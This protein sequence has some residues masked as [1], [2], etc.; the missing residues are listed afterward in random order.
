MKIFTLNKRKLKKKIR[1]LSIFIV[2]HLSLS[3]VRSVLLTATA[4]CIL[5]MLTPYIIIR[6]SPTEQHP[7]NDDGPPAGFQKF[8]IPKT[9]QVYRTETGK[10][11]TIDFE[12]YI[13]GVVSCEM[14]S[15]FH[16]EA[17]KAQAVAARTYSAAKAAAY[18]TD[19]N[20]E[21]HPDAP[22][23]DST[24]CQVYK[25]KN[26]LKSEKGS[27]WINSGWKKI[28]N[29]VDQTHGQ[30]L[31]YNGELVKQ[32]LFHSSSGGKTENSEDVFASAVPYLVSVDSPYEE[33]AT[34]QNEKNSFSI[35]E[36]KNLIE[37]NYPSISIGAVTAENTRIL[38]RSSGGSVKEIQIGDAVL[39]G[40]QIREALELP[41]AGF[42]IEISEDKITFTSSGSGHGVGMSQ[43]GADGMAE[44]G[45]DYKEILAHYYSGTKVY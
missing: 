20:P 19:G 14:P 15:D 40:R 45:Y 13:K 39:S 27:D 25:S 37:K 16:I 18:E 38:S 1:T 34:H 33:N 44:N 17:L 24:H 5:L 23:C 9:I 10:T 26:Q 4:L 29:A 30:L 35:S 21:E 41:S 28:S 22:L 2:R 7:E 36:F 43:Y 11:E 3:P 12:E 6:F 31:Y 42:S 32:A 8:D